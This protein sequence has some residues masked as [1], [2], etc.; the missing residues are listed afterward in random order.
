MQAENLD[1]NTLNPTTTM[2]SPDTCTHILTLTQGRKEEV[3]DKKSGPRNIRCVKNWPPEIEGEEEIFLG[4]QKG[5]L[6]FFLEGFNIFFYIV[7]FLNV[8][9]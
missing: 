8:A 4:P 3:K 5:F 6:K 1:Q 2:S 9:W 7:F